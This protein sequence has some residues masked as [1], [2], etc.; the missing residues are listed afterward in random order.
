MRILSRVRQDVRIMRRS[1]QII[2]T[3]K[4]VIIGL[5]LVARSFSLISLVFASSSSS[6]LDL[7][8]YIERQLELHI[9]RRIID[10]F[11]D[12][13]ASNDH[14]FLIKNSKVFHCDLRNRFGSVVCLTETN[15]SRIN[16]EREKD[17]MD[18]NARFL[19]ISLVHR[20]FDTF[21]LILF[22]FSGEIQ[23]QCSFFICKCTWGSITR[24][25]SSFPR[26]LFSMKTFKV[27]R[28]DLFFL[29][30]HVSSKSTLTSL[31]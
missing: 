1:L 28:I 16:R 5:V 11:F 8:I 21:Q 12:F 9:D 27:N 10:K 6:P 3:L 24:Q 18:R 20:D 14:F 2:T 23:Y 26:L 7:F 13:L 22:N 29:S 15:S 4:E 31:P 19:F 25:K 30:F 17:N